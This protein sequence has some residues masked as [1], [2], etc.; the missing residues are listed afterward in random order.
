MDADVLPRLPLS[1]GERTFEI[2]LE[3]IGSKEIPAATGRLL[4]KW[5]HEGKTL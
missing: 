2:H 4:R 3:S 5:L 1:E